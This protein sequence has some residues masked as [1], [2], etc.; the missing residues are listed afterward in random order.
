MKTDQ[1]RILPTMTETYGNQSGVDV[2]VS[3]RS[4]PSQLKR[5][6]GAPKHVETKVQHTGLLRESC[7][8]S[9]ICDI[10]KKPC[11]VLSYKRS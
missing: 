2:L 11:F 1:I 5:A 7:K 6:A 8:F 3:L 4:S 10:R 9:T